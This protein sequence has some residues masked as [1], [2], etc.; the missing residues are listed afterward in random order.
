MKRII[1]I[2]IFCYTLFSVTLESQ[3]P[4]PPP[5]PPPPVTVN[6][7]ISKGDSLL[8]TG[9][10]T[11]ALSEYRNM[12]SLK[13]TDRHYL[14]NIARAFSYAGES[15][16]SFRYLYLAMKERPDL[17]PLTDP[18]LLQLRDTEKWYD[19]ENEVIAEINTQT[20]QSIK[21]IEYAKKLCS[22]LCKDQYCFYE[23]GIA[24]RQLGPVSPVVTALRR[25]QSM[26]N[27]ENLAELE[28]LLALKGWPKISQVGPEAASA[29]FYVLQHSNG[30]SQQKYIELFRNTCIEK[31]G[32][33][34]QYALMFDRMR[35]NQ[36][37][38][39]KYG[40]HFILD[41]RATGKNILY[42]LENEA[43]VDEWRKEIG[44]E[45]LGDYLRKMNIGNGGPDK[46]Q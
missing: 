45:P 17:A 14:F 34:N 39:Q 21:D 18:G 9:N 27:K 2:L 44:L 7:Q 22:L 19:F 38:P 43:K 26:I 12:Y 23:T 29:A 5:P 42:P 11:A 1:A 37:L 33:W 4:P 32:N 24:V 41:N 6:G 35:M 40:T 25:L 3:T 46:N 31:E 15:D 16:S 30:D 28:T 13:R 36:N 20:N 8:M 10:I